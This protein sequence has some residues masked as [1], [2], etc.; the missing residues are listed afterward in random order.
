[1]ICHENATLVNGTKSLSA[2]LK[3]TSLHHVRTQWQADRL[4]SRSGLA[5]E[6]VHAGTLIF[7]FQPHENLMRTS[8]P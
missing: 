3:G 2:R 6:L 8:E 4:Q 1:M 5:P 7:D